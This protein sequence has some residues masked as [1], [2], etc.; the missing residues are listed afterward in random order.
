MTAMGG[1][2]LFTNAGT[3]Y[4]AGN[5]TTGDT[6][7]YGDFTQTADGILVF[8]ADAANFTADYLNIFGTANL[9][10][11]ILMQLHNVPA[12]L[13]DAPEFPN[14]EYA[15]A[16]L[17]ADNLVTG[18]GLTFD[19][20]ELSIQNTVAYTFALRVDNSNLWV[21]VVQALSKFRD[22]QTGNETDYQRYFAGYLDTQQE[23]DNNGNLS[24]LVDTLRNLPDTDALNAA[25]DQFAPYSVIAQQRF[26]VENA[27]GELASMPTCKATT[28]GGLCVFGGV[29]F[30]EHEGDITA[31]GNEY[32]TDAKNLRLGLGL[33]LSEN[34]DFGARVT[35]GDDDIDLPG[36]ASGEEKRL[37]ATFGLEGKLPAGMKLGA[38]ALAGGSDGE[39]SRASLLSSTS[40]L[41]SQ[42]ETTFY[43]GAVRLSKTFSAQG[44]GI[45]PDIGASWV[46]VESGGYAEAGTSSDAIKVDAWDSCQRAIGPGLGLASPGFSLGAFNTHMKA[47]LGLE[48]LE[49]DG[50]DVSARLK[51]APVITDRYVTSF[52]GEGST[53][54]TGMIGLSGA[55]ET[56]WQFGVGAEFSDTDAH[57]AWTL[58]LKIGK[59]L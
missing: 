38:M 24:D 13:S 10:G 27:R 4:V 43:G 53:R 46:C 35:L 47:R 59:A 32:S 36:D 39:F 15:F 33:K 1:S 25:F 11:T 9:N 14:G 41:V 29:S 2:S 50:L 21:D 34:W 22:M 49:D 26:L 40:P 37:S 3:V 17:Y 12:N 7:F 44:F 31:F 55:S 45:T 19:P 58:G 23:A 57:S 30:G 5:G 20:T 28:I 54:T 18:E 42:Q 52:D 48:A 16:I 6:D 51:Q 56:G 8:D